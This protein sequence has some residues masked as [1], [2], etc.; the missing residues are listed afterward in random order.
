M[1]G[2]S[3]SVWDLPKLATS[4]HEYRRSTTAD[5]RMRPWFPAVLAFIYRN[6]LV[7]A[8]QIRRRFPK[9][10][11]SERTTRRRLAEMQ[12]LGLL[13]THPTTGVSPLMPKVSFVTAAGVRR[14]KQAYRDQGKDWLAS[15]RSRPSPKQRAIVQPRLSR[16]GHDRVSALRLKGGRR[17]RRPRIAPAGASFARQ[18][19]GLRVAAAASL[20]TAQ[21]RRPLYIPTTWRRNDGLPRRDRHRHRE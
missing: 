14:L 10:M 20:R 1:S 6:R 18:P 9:Q 2:A 21:S 19:S 16:T 7:V 11:K 15:V 8:E 13:S 17:S 12:T 4:V 3:M 5:A